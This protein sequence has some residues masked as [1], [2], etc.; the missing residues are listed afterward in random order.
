MDNREELRTLVTQ[1]ERRLR[2]DRLLLF[3]V[4][5]IGFLGPALFLGHTGIAENPSQLFN[6]WSSAGLLALCLGFYFSSVLCPLTKR[7]RDLTTKENQHE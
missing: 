6:R 1:L 3:V 5:G 2:W 7:I 4:A